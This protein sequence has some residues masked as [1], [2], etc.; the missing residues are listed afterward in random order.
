MIAGKGPAR[1]IGTMHAGGKP[2]DQ[3]LRIVIAKRGHRT[4]VI[5][6]IFCGRLI[7]KICKSGTVPAIRVKFQ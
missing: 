6:R 7:K 1:C 3:Q 4:G 2:D 5:A